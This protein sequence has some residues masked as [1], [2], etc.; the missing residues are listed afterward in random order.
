MLFLLILSG[1]YN[2]KIKVTKCQVCATNCLS[3]LLRSS[4]TA[5]F[6]IYEI[7]LKKNE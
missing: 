1:V 2:N 7:I 5:N 3:T 6:T 4:V